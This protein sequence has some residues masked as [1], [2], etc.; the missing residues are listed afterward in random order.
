[1]DAKQVKDLLSRYIDRNL[2]SV[3]TK[4]SRKQYKDIKGQKRLG[5]DSETLEITIRQDKTHNPLIGVNQAFA[6]REAL[7]KHFN[8]IFYGY[9]DET[10][11]EIVEPHS[12]RITPKGYA[13]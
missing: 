5:T 13:S 11:M 4:H 7:S 10:G 8:L 1:M 9:T 2:I 3:K 6:H 12:V